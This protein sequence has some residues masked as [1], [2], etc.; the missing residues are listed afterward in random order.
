MAM[1]KLNDTLHDS[2]LHSLMKKQG[3]EDMAK[4]MPNRSEGTECTSHAIDPKNILRE[5]IK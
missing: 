2:K 5:K 4:L 1:H 3:T